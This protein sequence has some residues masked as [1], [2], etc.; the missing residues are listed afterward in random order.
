MAISFVAAAS[1]GTGVATSVSIDVPTGTQNGDM[2]VAVFGNGDAGGTEPTCS[3]WTRI[4]YVEDTAGSDGMI[5]MFYRVASGE[6]T[7]YTFSYPSSSSNQTSGIIGTYRGVDGALDVSYVEG[8]H[9]IK[10]LDTSG[11]S[12]PRAITTSTDGAFVIIGSW[13]Q[14]TSTTSVTPSSGYTEAAELIE[15]NR[16]AHLQHKLVSPAGTETPGSITANGGLSTLD[17]HH[18]TIAIRP[19]TEVSLLSRSHRGVMRGVARGT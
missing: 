5:S 3:G 7:D 13:W 17:M 10:N 19:A 11:V 15:N 12:T 14:Q 9:Y 18:I 4:G 8:S 6:P 2:M 1:N 16:F